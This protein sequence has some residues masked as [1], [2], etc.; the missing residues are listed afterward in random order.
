MMENS[1]D[2]TIRLAKKFAD[3]ND[4]N[5]WFEAFYAKAEG[6]INKVYWADLKPNPLLL[7]WVSE[8]TN[9]AGKRP[10]PSGADWVTM[11]KLWRNR[12]SR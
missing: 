11:Q 8:R 3:R 9:L 5:G 4:P 6:D 10:L 1:K 7:D 2:A 12:D